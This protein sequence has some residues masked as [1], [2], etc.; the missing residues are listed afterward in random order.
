MREHFSTLV[1][2]GLEDR[3]TFG[4]ALVFLA[5]G[6]VGLAL[7]T[8]TSS[9]AVLGALDSVQVLEDIRY[10]TWLGVYL[11]LGRSLREAFHRQKQQQDKEVASENFAGVAHQ[12]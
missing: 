5:G 9:A 10:T 2:E 7:P 1:P 8:S 11:L 6:P 4:V 12:E 3:A